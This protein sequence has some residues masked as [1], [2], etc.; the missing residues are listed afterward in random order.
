MLPGGAGVTQTYDRQGRPVRIE[1]PGVLET[2]RYDGHGR[3]SQ[4]TAPDGRTTR[5][6]YERDAFGRATAV[7][8][9]GGRDWKIAW[10]HGEVAGL[11]GPMGAVAIEQGHEN[12]QHLTCSLR[13]DLR[14][15]RSRG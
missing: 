11:D 9:P 6:R 12:G 3:V 4:H 15:A 13:T 14:Y 1:A 2:F 7:H 8:T 10:A 5:Y